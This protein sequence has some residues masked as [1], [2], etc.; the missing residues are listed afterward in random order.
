METK[1]KIVDSVSI[2]VILAGGIGPDNVA[3][4]IA[5]VGPFGVD[6]KTKT[7]LSGGTGK[8]I[9]KVKEFIRIA[10]STK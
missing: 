9:E 4:A 5:T 10:K 8:D 3:V 6:S 1:Q 2:P 7:D